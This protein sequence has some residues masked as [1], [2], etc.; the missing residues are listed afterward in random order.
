MF[1]KMNYFKRG[2]RC[3]PRKSVDGRKWRDWWVRRFLWASYHFRGH[4]QIG[5]SST[6]SVV[7]ISVIENYWF[8]DKPLSVWIF[9]PDRRAD[10]NLQGSTIFNR[11]KIFFFLSGAPWGKTFSSSEAAFTSRVFEI[12]NSP[13]K[14]KLRLC[15]TSSRLA[16]RPEH[17]KGAR[18]I[19]T[20]CTSLPR[21][22]RKPLSRNNIWGWSGR[23]FQKRGTSQTRFLPSL[24][25]FCESIRTAVSKLLTPLAKNTY[26]Q[27]V[28]TFLLVNVANPIEGL[29]MPFRNRRSQERLLSRVRK[30]KSHFT[31]F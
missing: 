25:D 4:P 16:A 17:F 3:L 5:F 10:R 26:S 29:T 6:I 8:V 28:Y 19:Q 31:I 21:A 9:V 24:A 15:R 20:Y 2:K 27:I 22:R 7:K 13:P 11:T 23:V 18:R 30:I 14:R 12:A 1:A